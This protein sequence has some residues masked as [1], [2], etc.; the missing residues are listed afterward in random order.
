MGRPAKFNWMNM[1]IGDIWYVTG[2]TTEHAQQAWY[3]FKSRN[4]Y[5]ACRQYLWH[6]VNGGVRIERVG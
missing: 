5:V 3:R 6:P 2:A 1:D 4:P